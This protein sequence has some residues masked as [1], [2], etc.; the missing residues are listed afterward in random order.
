M[1][2]TT[3]LEFRIFGYP[4]PQGS[5]KSL[6]NGI[7][8]ESCKHTKTWRQDIRQAVM[9]QYSGSVIDGAVLVEVTFLFP[10]P[11]G[12]YGTGRNSA[13]LKPSAPKH[14]VSSQLGDLDK[15]LR[16]TLDGLNLNAGGVLLKDDSLVVDARGTKRYCEE[17]ELP[18]AYLS[19]EV[20]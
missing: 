18:G 5:K 20:L 14:C 7:L 10:R 4:R 9:N 2:T 13:K 15:L 6:G 16:S 17:G 12:H 19:V 11:K 3:A 8:V 1:Q